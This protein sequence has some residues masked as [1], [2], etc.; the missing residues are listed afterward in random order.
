[1]TPA[2]FSGTVAR[3]D[4]GSAVRRLLESVQRWLGLAPASAANQQTAIVQV[5]QPWQGVQRSPV[6]VQTDGGAMCGLS[7]TAGQQYV[8]Y[9][10]ETSGRL[11]ASICSRTTNLRQAAVDLAFLQTQPMLTVRS[12]PGL[13]LGA[14]AALLVGGGAAGAAA[15]ALWSARRRAR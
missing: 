13:I 6:E 8:I 2:V 9:A 14:I 15:G 10:Y 1:M 5:S 12:T 11:S 3:I 4:T 7:F